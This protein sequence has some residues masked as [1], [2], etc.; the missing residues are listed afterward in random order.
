MLKRSCSPNDIISKREVGFL[1]KKV[2]TPNNGA[3]NNISKNKVEVK[4]KVKVKVKR[5][6]P[7]SVYNAHKASPTCKPHTLL[8]RGHLY[9]H[10]NT[11]IHSNTISTFKS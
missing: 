4:V 1:L 10:N 3:P 5:C 9:V 2:S 11:G 7:P 6:H 8:R